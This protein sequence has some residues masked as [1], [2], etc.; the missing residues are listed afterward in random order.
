[1]NCPLNYPIEAKDINHL[2]GR[3]YYEDDLIQ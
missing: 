2:K 1:V 3:S